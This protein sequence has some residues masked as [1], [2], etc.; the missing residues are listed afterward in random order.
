MQSWDGG[1]RKLQLENE[2][3]QYQRYTNPLVNPAGEIGSSLALLSS[4][5]EKRL[6]ELDPNRINVDI[7]IV[8]WL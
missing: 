7:G 5:T 2:G 3:S 8:A 6:Y 1:K 4:S